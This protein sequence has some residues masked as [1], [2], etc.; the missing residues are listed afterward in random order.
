MPGWGMAL[1]YGLELINRILDAC[2]PIRKLQ[3]EIVKL[4]NAVTEAQ[5]K[6]DLNELKQKRAELEDARHRLA[7]GDY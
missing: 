6:G 3:R 2:A 1:G 5:V 4:E 7:T